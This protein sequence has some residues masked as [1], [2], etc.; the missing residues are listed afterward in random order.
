M[1]RKFGVL[2]EVEANATGPSFID[3]LVLAELFVSS[4]DVSGRGIIVAS[5]RWPISAV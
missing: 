2:V 1:M 5:V 4:G 3:P